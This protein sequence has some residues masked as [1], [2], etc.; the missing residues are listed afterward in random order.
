MESAILLFSK[1]VPPF[2]RSWIMRRTQG[3]NV[4]FSNPGI[5]E[6]DFQYF[7]DGKT[8]ILDCA[9]FGGLVPPYDLMI[10]TSTVNGKMQIDSIFNKNIFGNCDETFI[11]P[12]LGYL[13]EIAESSIRSSQN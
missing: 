12:F 3:S 7:G 11:R 5:I 10:V 9:I 4:F 6:E 1:L 2:L 13:H 8:P